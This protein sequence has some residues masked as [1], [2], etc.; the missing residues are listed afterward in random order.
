MSQR[1]RIVDTVH[2]ISEV[3]V[4]QAVVGLG[5]AEAAHEQAVSDV[6]ALEADNAA[7]EADLTGSGALGGVE[8]ELLWAHRA[9]AS[10]AR[11]NTEERLAISEA[12]VEAAKVRLT[13]S[14][15]TT[16]VREAAKERVHS[17]AR[18]EREAR[19]QRELDEI[20]ITRSTRRE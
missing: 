1:E 18:Q 11:V 6:E 9:W 8:R 4:R 7:A 3:H 15:Q 14:K 13:E 20:A 19:S 16:R 10:R 17:E 12:Q 2:R 5:R